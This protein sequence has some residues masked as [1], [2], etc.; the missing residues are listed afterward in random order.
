MPSCRQWY[1]TTTGC[2]KSAYPKP[3]ANTVSAG[4]TCRLPDNR[5]DPTLRCSRA[6]R[7]NPAR[8]RTS[9]PAKRNRTTVGLS[10]TSR[11]MPHR[12]RSSRRTTSG[13]PCPA[14]AMSSTLLSRYREQRA[15]EAWLHQGRHLNFPSNRTTHQRKVPRPR[16]DQLLHSR[17][18]SPRRPPRSRWGR[19]LRPTRV[20]LF[21]STSRKPRP[22]RPHPRRPRSL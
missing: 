18:G 19:R 1:A 15:G 17:A 5:S 9:T 22:S 4:I 21:T 3:T 20:L 10:S 14:P 7:I 6:P 8:L 13:R 12:N 2:W 11:R 16:S